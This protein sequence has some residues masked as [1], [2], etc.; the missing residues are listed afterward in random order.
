MWTARRC[1]LN[2]RRERAHVRLGAKRAGRAAFTLIELLVVVSIIALLISI[3]LPSLRGARE[4]AR[5]VVC[6][7]QQGSL[8]RG[9]STYF[10]ENNDWIPGYNTSSVEFRA[11]ERAADSDITVLHQSGLPVQNHDW[12]TPLVKSDTKLPANRAER[13]H[14]ITGFQIDALSGQLDGPREGRG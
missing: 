4:Q 7:S 11:L 13:F 6:G 8:G 14:L 2:D 3:L 1:R 10:A 5:T 9:L 12:L